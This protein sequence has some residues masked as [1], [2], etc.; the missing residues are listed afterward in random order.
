MTSVKKQLCH[1]SW[2]PLWAKIRIFFLPQK[3]KINIL[4]FFFQM[5]RRLFKINVQVW[6]GRIKINKRLKVHGYSIY[7]QLITRKFKSISRSCINQYKVFTY[8]S[9]SQKRLFVLYFLNGKWC[10]IHITS[11]SQQL[12]NREK[13]FE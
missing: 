2:N 9:L 7:I 11:T 12:E 3:D 10:S 6:L 13:I 5:G 1:K 8:L 4:Y